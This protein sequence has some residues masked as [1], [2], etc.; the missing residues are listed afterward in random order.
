M[1]NAEKNDNKWNVL[2]GK[3][4]EGNAAKAF[5]FFREN[6][7]EPILIK[8]FASA[9]WYPPE[10]GRSYLD[11]DLCVRTE[12]FDRCEELI[13][14]KAPKGVVI[15]L[16]REFR[17]LDLKRWDY[18]FEKTEI[19]E[20]N[21]V[22]IRLLSPED[23]LRVLCN[24]WLTDGAENKQRLWDIFYAVDRRP[25]NFDWNQCLDVV[26]TNRRLW[27]VYSIGLAHH[28]LGLDISKLPFHDEARDI[29]KWIRRE[30]ERNWK[31]NVPI[32]PLNSCKHDKK[33]LWQQLKKRFPPNPIFSTVSMDGNLN[34]RSRIH[35]Q[36]GNFFM[37]L[38]L[39]IRG[40]KGHFLGFR[41]K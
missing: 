40:V 3:L 17:Y 12:D 1:D 37:R 22:D 26:S 7:I 4:Q 27:V 16:H 9:R 15:D 34:A 23:H 19:V 39:A 41:R 25:A 30:V 10:V 28:Y 29:P 20:I 6:G 5:E 31:M 13:A 24:H 32:V 33:A 21:G 35:Y 36:I 2:Q 18:L 8:G 14:K 38:I 11:V